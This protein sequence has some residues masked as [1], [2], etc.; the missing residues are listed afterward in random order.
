MR[1][2]YHATR[3]SQSGSEKD[4]CPVV[5]TW[6]SAVSTTS[7]SGSERPKPKKKTKIR[8]VIVKEDFW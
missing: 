8:R 5:A 2:D 4:T 3:T 7:Q 6:S 1:E